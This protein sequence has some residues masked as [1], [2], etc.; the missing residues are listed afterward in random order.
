[1]TGTASI[2]VTVDGARPLTELVATI[3]AACDGIED[4]DIEPV[5][6]LRL[7]PGAPPWPGDVGIQEV[8]RWE[9]TVR[10]VEQLPAL[11]VAVATGECSGV[12]ADLLLTADLRIG[13]PD[14]R[15]S[16]GGATGRLWPGMALHRLAQQVG[17]GRARQVAMSGGVL[18]ASQARDI[19][20]LDRV[21]D[22]VDHVPTDLPDG[23]DFRVR[24]QLLIE[25]ASTGYQEALGMHLAACDRELRRLHRDADA[26]Q[27][28]S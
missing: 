6:L 12:C 15:I 20:V 13:T 16:F 27:V 26:N 8:N 25:A 14:L 23:T 28:M 21:T 7:A 4:A 22:T 9:R 10:R 1:M 11:V 24:R 18:T 3:N 19:A 5:L 17:V 2:E